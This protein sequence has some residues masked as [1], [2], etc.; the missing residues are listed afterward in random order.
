LQTSVQIFNRLRTR[1][2]SVLMIC[3]LKNFF[4]GVAILAGVAGENEGIAA[5]SKRELGC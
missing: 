3:I 2:S 5:S 4:T 1:Q